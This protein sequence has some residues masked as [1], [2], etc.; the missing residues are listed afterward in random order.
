MLNRFE[1]ST[2]ALPKIAP[3]KPMN[4]RTEVNSMCEDEID[5][6]HLEVQLKLKAAV[7]P[8]FGTKGAKADES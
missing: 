5:T 8:C 7:D 2:P 1:P 3:S 4:A 6:Y